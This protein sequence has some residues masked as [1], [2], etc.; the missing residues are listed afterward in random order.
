MSLPLIVR[1]CR[2]TRLLMRG[3][4]TI[5]GSDKEASSVA[6]SGKGKIVDRGV[7]Y[8]KIFIYV[9]MDVVKDSTFPF[10]VG[11]DVEITIEGE[12]LVVRKRRRRKPEKAL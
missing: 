11:E 8:P 5:M 1:K 9:P 7:K 4:V 2:S 3:E 10:K 12:M 6:R